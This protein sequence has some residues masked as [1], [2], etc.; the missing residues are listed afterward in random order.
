VERT[1]HPRSSFFRFS[2]SSSSSFVS[3]DVQSHQHVQKK[4]KK[5]LGVEFKKQ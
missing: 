3:R 5:T 4:K 2:S 1:V